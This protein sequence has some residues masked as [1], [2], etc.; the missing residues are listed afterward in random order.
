MRKLLLPIDSG[1][2]SE[3]LKNCVKDFAVDIKSDVTLLY[4]IP[5]AP[6]EHN[7]M[8]VDLYNYREK[9]KEQFEAHA[10]ELLEKAEADLRALG[11]ETI[12]KTIASGDPADEILKMIESGQYHYVIMNTHG[13][14]A[15]RRLLIGSVTN[16]IVHHSDIPVLTVK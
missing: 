12:E 2:L 10:N 11:V 6:V 4:V 1:D 14:G 7:L 15:V 16:K 8:N 9:N 5:V 13:M 3:N